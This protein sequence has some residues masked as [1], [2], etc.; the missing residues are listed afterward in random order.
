MSDVAKAS[1]A[2][3]AVRMVGTALVVMFGTDRE[4]ELDFIADK[5]G[6]TLFHCRRQLRMNF[7]FMALLDYA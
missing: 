3:P 1:I 6:L 4:A 7:G 2:M 5:P